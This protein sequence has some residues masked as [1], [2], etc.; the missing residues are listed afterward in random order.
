M[1][2][3][4][5]L[6]RRW[7]PL[8]R[9]IRRRPVGSLL[10]GILALGFA[11]QGWQMIGCA[12][13]RWTRPHVSYRRALES[14]VAVSLN[15]LEG[16][17]GTPATLPRMDLRGAVRDPAHCDWILFGDVSQDRPSLPL[18]VVAV[19]MR[20][21]QNELEFPGIDIRPAGE[22]GRESPA[23]QRVRYFGGVERTLVG[24][25]FFRFDYWMK[26]VSL[27][28][29][30]APVRGLPVYWQR[31]VQRLEREVRDC[32]DARPDR[33]VHRN[34]YW[35]CA[36]DF[37]AIEDGDILVLGQT[38]LRV[39][40]ER[41][42]AWG[43]SAASCPCTS[44]GTDDPDAAAFSD[45]LTANL[46][47]VDG[48]VPVTEIETF[49]RMLSSL[50][51]LGERDPY[52]DADPWLRARVPAVDTPATVPSTTLRAEREHTLTSRDGLVI[53]RHV[54]EICG[55]VAVMPSLIRHRSS[56]GSL[57]TLRQTILAARPSGS[58]ASWRF[59]YRDLP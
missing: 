50:A 23:Q 27:Q 29:E 41:V 30:P 53:H 40:A 31:A 5:K 59:T 49:A 2:L 17:I 33:R 10:A 46:G 3:S 58:P 22:G 8:M 21:V 16:Q 47:E 43:S 52:R 7:R 35:L 12:W 4:V 57:H 14:G 44:S 38:P 25:W 56:D 24:Q 51:W 34:R 32:T 45:W 13:E 28:Q 55:G 37:E 9:A 6:E 42:D 1:K 26:L 36:S 19:A 15:A 11:L 20:S 18:D 48:L 54:L 39:L